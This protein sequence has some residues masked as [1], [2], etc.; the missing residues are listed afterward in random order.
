MFGEH[1]LKD[2]KK[3]VCHLSSYL[4]PSAFCPCIITDAE[5][6]IKVEDSNRK[7]NGEARE[8]IRQ[9]VIPGD[10]IKVSLI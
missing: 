5:E 10:V 7:S 9:L 4:S 1:L 2:F 3:L 8:N 6:F